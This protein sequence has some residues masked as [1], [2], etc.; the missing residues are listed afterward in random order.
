MIKPQKLNKWDTIWI[1]SP[2]WWWPSLY[3]HIYESW[4][5]VLTQL[6]YKIKEF[7]SVRADDDY[8]YSNPEFR[9]NDINNAFADKEVQAI[10]A[11]IWWDDS[12][13]ILKYLDTNT[14]INNPK[15]F[16]WYSDNSIITTYLNQLWLV[17]FNWPTIM[18]GLSQWNDLWEEFHKSFIDFFE[19]NWNY[20][21]KPFPF[22]TNWYLD[23]WNK[24][25]VWK[26]K[27]RVKHDW[28]N[29]LQ[30]SWKFSWELFGG[31]LQTMEFLKWTIYYPKEEFWE[32]KILFLEI[33]EDN[34][35][36]IDQIMRAMRNYAVTW[37]FNKIGW[38]LVWRARDYSAE[39]KKLLNKIILNVINWEFWITNLPIITN[40]DF[41]HTDPQWVLPL[42]INAEF[43]IKNRSFKLL[44]KCFI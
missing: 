6:W 16:M 37:V 41:W 7:P 30:W 1:I 35:A 2:S 32:N 25:Y 17:T 40:L 42:W 8:L 13:R 28:W 36:Q 19:N 26:I 33:A 29:I 21:Y 10:I 20:E 3:N 34:W 11:T 24:E 27:E 18:A 22:Y 15:M 44:E 5:N 39:E 9:A 38:L 12:I 31:C 4:I 43:D 14:I 23:W